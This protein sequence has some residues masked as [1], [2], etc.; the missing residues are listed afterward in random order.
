MCCMVHCR[1]VLRMGE[2]NNGGEVGSVACVTPGH[3]GSRS[4]WRLPSIDDHCLFSV[5]TLGLCC[6]SKIEKLNG[7]LETI[8]ATVKGYNPSFR[9]RSHLHY[10]TCVPLPPRPPSSI[11]HPPF[12]HAS[13]LIHPQHQSHT[14]ANSSHSWTPSSPSHRSRPSSASA[15]PTLVLTP[16]LVLSLHPPP[17]STVSQRTLTW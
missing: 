11:S 3:T 1:A 5:L 7:R 10:S 17:L 4:E 13:S 14:H 16:I 8:F 2:G 12:A 15:C 9:A 6:R